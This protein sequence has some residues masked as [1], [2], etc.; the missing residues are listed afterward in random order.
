MRDVL[1]A[2]IRRLIPLVPAEA[3]IGLVCDREADLAK[4]VLSW[5]DDLGRSERALY[6]R[7]AGICYMNSRDVIILQIADMMAYLFREYAEQR[8]RDPSLPVNPLLDRMTKS[9]MVFLRISSLAA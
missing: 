8:E 3:Q 2:V 1:S 5:I 4:E 6:D 7:I 9:Q